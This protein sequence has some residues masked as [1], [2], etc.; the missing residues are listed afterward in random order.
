[1]CAWSIRWRRSLLKSP[2]TATYYHASWPLF[3]FVVGMHFVCFKCSW[4]FMCVCV[5]LCLDWVVADLWIFVN[6]CDCEWTQRGQQMVLLPDVYQWMSQWTW[7]TLPL[8]KRHP[9]HI[10]AERKKG[11]NGTVWAGAGAETVKNTIIH[12]L[13]P[14]SL[15]VVMQ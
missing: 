5:V 4:T 11:M 1:M 15:D 14:S 13:Q 6:V 8:S 2:H 9:V 3:P 12:R 7:S 10:S